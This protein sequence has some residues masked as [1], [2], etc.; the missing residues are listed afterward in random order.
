MSLNL[1]DFTHFSVPGVTGAGKSS[2]INAVFGKELAKT[3]GWGRGAA[4]SI[5]RILIS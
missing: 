3:G 1:G 2:L 5:I 4:L